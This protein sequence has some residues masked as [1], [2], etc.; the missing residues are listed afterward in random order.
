VG[1]FQADVPGAS[2]LARSY[3]PRD[4]AFDAGPRGVSPCEVRRLFP[5]ASGL[6]RLVLF[7]RPDLYP[8]AG[9]LGTREGAEG[10]A[11]AGSAVGGR[12]PYLHGVVAAN[13]HLRGPLDALVPFG[14]GGLL[15]LPVDA[16]VL[17]PE[18][19]PGA[20]LP[21][22]IRAGGTEQVHSVPSLTLGQKLR[23]QIAG[24]YELRFGEQ[25]FLRESLVDEGVASPSAT[26]AGA[27]CTSVTMLGS[28]SSQ[29][30]VMCTR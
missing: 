19:L 29:V 21:A 14:A 15:A 3:R 10:P 22:V 17:R 8:P 25:T 5:V 24:V 9:V 4:G 12:E 27:V 16:E 30:S 13:V 1:L 26:G 18:A 23:V 7:P 2:H 6:E 28:P 20:G 11:R